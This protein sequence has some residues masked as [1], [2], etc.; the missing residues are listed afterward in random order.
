MAEGSRVRVSPT[1]C[2]FLSLGVREACQPL[3]HRSLRVD[4][5]A[6]SYAR[7]REE[8]DREGNQGGMVEGSKPS[9]TMMV[10]NATPGVVFVAAFHH[11]R[12]IGL[13][14]RRP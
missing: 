9:P 3:G 11:Q 7:Q 2:C 10:M 13:F 4:R 6:R 8:C 14:E 5:A 12:K 1:T